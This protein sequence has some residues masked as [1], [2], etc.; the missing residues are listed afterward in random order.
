MY[1]SSIAEKYFQTG[2]IKTS[3][4]F[5]YFDFVQEQEQYFNPNSL[6]VLHSVREI[7]KRKNGDYSSHTAE[8]SAIRNFELGEAISGVSPFSAI[9]SRLSDKIG[10]LVNLLEEYA[11]KAVEYFDRTNNVLN[12]E[13]YDGCM[14]LLDNIIEELVIT[15]RKHEQPNITLLMGIS[16]SLVISIEKLL[17]Q[18]S[19]Q[20]TVNESLID[21]AK[22]LVGYLSLAGAI[23]FFEQKENKHE[24]LSRI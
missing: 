11:G 7:V 12:Q 16:C 24:D 13:E 20:H 17:S 9:L 1:R 3:D 21:T 8:R 18:V 23:L 14:I 19:I 15:T 4:L 2:N 22:D 5:A 10:R 6:K